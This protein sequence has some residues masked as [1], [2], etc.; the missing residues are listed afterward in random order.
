VEFRVVDDLRRCGS[1]GC[2]RPISACGFLRSFAGVRI[3]RVSCCICDEGGRQTRF[4]GALSVLAE[5]SVAAAADPGAA[6][7]AEPCVVAAAR[8]VRRFCRYHEERG[9]WR[10]SGRRLL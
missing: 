9:E 10:F 4:T 8:C 3:L 7:Q 6:L 2:V 5:S 1:G